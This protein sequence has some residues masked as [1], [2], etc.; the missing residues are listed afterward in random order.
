M[1]VFVYV[2]FVSVSYYTF[3]VDFTTGSAFEIVIR[4]LAVVDEL[5]DKVTLPRFA[6]IIDP[7]NAEV[8]CE[9]TTGGFVV[10]QS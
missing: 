8:G 3:L 4:V 1:C 5:G 2:G 7:I 10:Q 9:A 6:H